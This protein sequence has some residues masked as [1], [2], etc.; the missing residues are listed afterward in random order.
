MQSKETSD[1]SIPGAGLTRRGLLVG[2][3]ALGLSVLEVDALGGVVN[4]ATPQTARTQASGTVYVEIDAGQNQEPITKNTPAMQKKFGIAVKQVALPFVGQ[5]EKLVT[6][7]IARSGAYDLM[8]FPP[9]FLGDFVA[10]KF[11]LPLES[12][13]AKRDPLVNTLLPV[14]RDT[15]TIKNGKRYA[16]TYDGDILY[17]YYRRDLWNDP[18]EKKDFQKKYG[19]PLAPPKTWDQYL[20]QARFFNRPP[21]LHG[22]AF[23]GQRGFSYGWWAN[24]WAGLG[25][26]WFDARTMKTQINSPAGLKALNY[27]LEMKKVS[28]PDVLSYGYDALRN[29]FFLGK[30]AMC[31]QWGDLHKKSFGGDPQAPSKIAGKLGSAPCPNGKSYMPYSRIGAISASG[32]NLDGAYDVLW[33]LQQP[34]VS[35]DYVTDPKNGI[36]A[37]RYSN[38]R[39]ANWIKRFPQYPALV[40]EYAKT[41]RANLLQGFPELSIPGAPTYIDKLDL[42]INQ[43][44]AGQIKPKVALDSAAREWE[45]LTDSLD[46]NAQRQAYLTWISTFRKAGIKY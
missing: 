34:A 5:Y 12:Y 10:K 19:Y 3:A 4:A 38:L 36:D 30:F 28:P 20:D 46:R 14:F 37:C 39:P 35:D 45:S 27:L 40:T 13:A 15:I 21:H 25:G 29:A 11:V 6:E 41:M 9:Y 42:Y 26:H 17:V 43:A 18:T 32:K 23:Y 1:T 2:A 33:Y 31:V 8:F 24:I 22:T 7:L 16:L 44:L